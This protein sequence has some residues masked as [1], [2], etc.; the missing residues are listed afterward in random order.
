MST[1]DLELDAKESQ[2]PLLFIS[3]KHCDQ[4]IATVISTFVRSIS[5]GNVAVYQSSNPSFESPRVGKELTKELEDALWHA[6][7]VLL[8]YTSQ[9]QDWSWCMWEC[10]VALQPNSPDTKVVVLQCLKDEPQVFKGSV[11]VLSWDEA[12]VINFAKRFADPDFFPNLGRAVT[13][14]SER[15]LEAS[16]L[17]LHKALRDAIPQQ[18][19]ENWNAWPY[20]RIQ[21]PR[22]ALDNLN[23]VGKEHRL[24]E[25]RKIILKEAIVVTTDSGLPQ[26]FRLSQVSN[27]MS[28]QDLVS[29]WS[30]HYPDHSTRWLDVLVQQIVHGA[31]KQT[32]TIA[33][34]RHLR[35]VKSNEESIPGVGRIKGDAANLQFDI[36]FYG[37]ASVPLVESRMN[38][39]DRMYY[40]DLSNESAPQV[41]LKELLAH[42]ESL[43][44]SRLPILNATLPKHVIHVCDIDRFLRQKAFAQNAIDTLTLADLLADE[45]IVK[46]LT[47][48]WETISDQC[49]LEEARELM[50]GKKKCQ[51]LFVTATGSRN[52]AV[53]GW[54]TDR[55]IHTYFTK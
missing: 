51:D 54:L 29:G 19:R 45:A 30:E 35:H 33:E 3:H 8:V 18:Q 14:L 32:P 55:D 49:T 20:L 24:A 4:A 11:H 22:C 40:L 42:L 15:E 50:R 52:E 43:N 39:L 38:T 44:W 25:A 48:A 10:G 53:L 16:A 12:S 2:K 31:F 27:D 37:V 13:G 41:N 26:I 47:D 21:I 34:W 28:L 17:N 23:H 46:R 36:Y 1:I 6:G 7:I 5:G 9:D